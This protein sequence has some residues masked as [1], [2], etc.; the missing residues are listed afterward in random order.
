MSMDFQTSCDIRKISVVI[1]IR[2]RLDGW[3]LI[4]GKGKVF[5]FNHEIQT[6][7]GAH[8]VTYLMGTGGCFFRGKAAEA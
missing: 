7:S 6:G 4:P 1:A 5:S 3:S 2:Y 8:P